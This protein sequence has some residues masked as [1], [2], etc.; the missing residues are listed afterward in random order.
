MSFLQTPIS[1]RTFLG[2]SRK[3]DDIDVDVIIDE[4]TTDNVTLTR[5]PIQ[6]GAAISDHSYAEPVE[7][8]MRAVFRSSLTESLSDV[9]DKLQEIQDFGIPVTITTPKRVYEAMM[10]TSLTCTT[11]KSTENILS[12]QFSFQEIIIVPIST[13]TVPR[14]LQ[15]LKQATLK[16]EK[17]GKKTSVLKRIVGSL[18]GAIGG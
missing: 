13:T 1:L 14:D 15:A 11:D 7:L 4:S 16:T 8:K 17:V 9:Y 3:I 18:T 10:L 12:V 6:H 2:A 5:N